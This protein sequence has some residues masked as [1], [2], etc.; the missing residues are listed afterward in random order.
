MNWYHLASLALG[1]GCIVL[2]ALVPATAPYL[3]PAGGALLL[4]TDAAKVIGS[5]PE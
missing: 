4:G 1:V 3:L 5:K 2:G